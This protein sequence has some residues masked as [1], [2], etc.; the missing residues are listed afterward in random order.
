MPVSQAVFHGSKQ[1]I[2]QRSTSGEYKWLGSTPYSSQSKY[3]LTTFANWGRAL[4]CSVVT[5]SCLSIFATDCPSIFGPNKLIVTDKDR[6]WL[7]QAGLK[8]HR[9]RH[10]A[11]T[12]KC[13][14]CSWRRE[15]SVLPSVCIP[16]PVYHH[17]F[18]LLGL[19]RWT[20]LSYTV[21]NQRMNPFFLLLKTL[22]TSK[23]MP[24]N[25]S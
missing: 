11:G 23:Q 6:L 8:G 4:L 18:L 15:Y 24:N 12:T 5:L 22:L 2:V 19:S 14:T 10:Q 9:R 20:H 21:T 3:I 16:V 13:K 1:V 7:F 17:D 25:I